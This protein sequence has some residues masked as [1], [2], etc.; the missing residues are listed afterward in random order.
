MAVLGDRDGPEVCNV[1]HQQTIRKISIRIVPI[2]A[3][4]FLLS[5]IDRTNISIAALDMNAD[6]GL[7]PTAFGWAIS[8]FFFSYIIFEVPS[9]IALRRFGARLWLARIMLTW[10][11]ISAATA[12]ATGPI[13]LYILRSLLGAAEAGYAVGVVYYFTLWFPQAYRTRMLSYF[14]VSTPLALVIGSPISGLLLGLNGYLRGWQWLFLLEGVPSILLG[15]I[16]LFRLPDEPRAAMWLTH[17]EQAWLIDTLRVEQKSSHQVADFGGALRSGRVWL[18][19]LCYLFI[20][21]T[22]LGLGYWLPQ[23]IKT[24]GV[25]NS[26]VGLLAAAPSLAA[27]FG[28]LVWSRAAQRTGRSERHVAGGCFVGFLSLGIAVFAS[29]PLVSFV[30]IVVSYVGLWSAWGIFWSVVTR[31]LAGPGSATAIAFISA[32]GTMSGVFGPYLIGWLLQATGDY[33]T[34]I[35]ALSLSAVIAALI[36]LAFR[37]ERRTI[38]SRH[39]AE[40]KSART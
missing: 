1:G 9:N 6:L 34:G 31:T 2:A 3:L 8:L 4:G 12:F 5:Y 14:F 11:L 21:I 26:T 33:R 10:G 16:I 40:A 36:A 24:Y 19:S 7:S 27:I 20:L 17:D 23:M 22:I 29:S 18:L 13:S 32:F 15:F 25:T 38:D 30:A 35:M 28:M 39:M 37:E